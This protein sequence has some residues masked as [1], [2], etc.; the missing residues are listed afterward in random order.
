MTSGRRVSR[1]SP[2][3]AHGVPGPYFPDIVLPMGTHS[4]IAD[5]YAPRVARRSGDPALVLVARVKNDLVDTIAVTPV[6][7]VVDKITG[8]SPFLGEHRTPS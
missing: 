1:K 6:R 8:V 4:N 5:A 7:R 2:T 3:A